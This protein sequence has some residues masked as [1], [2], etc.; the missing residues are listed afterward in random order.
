MSDIGANTHRRQYEGK[1]R[2]QHH[3]CTYTYE[4]YRPGLPNSHDESTCRGCEYRGTCN[5]VYREHDDQIL[6]ERS[7]QGDESD[8]D[9]E[10]DGSF[11]QDASSQ[12]DSVIDDVFRQKDD[13]A[14]DEDTDTFASDDDNDNDEE[15]YCIERKCNG[16]LD[17]AL[18]GEVSPIHSF[19]SHPTQLI[20][21]RPTSNTAKHGTTTNSTAACVNGTDSSRSS[22]SQRTSTHTQH[23]DSGCGYSAGIS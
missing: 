15:E 23:T 9:G 19:S 2:I 10:D 14:M 12:Y 4:A 6:G 16:V 11:I 5:I 7:T 13:D 17:I 20:P 8:A 3:N 1:L 21:H 18:V 22:V